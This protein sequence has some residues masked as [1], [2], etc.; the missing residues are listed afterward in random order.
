MSDVVN[1]HGF[2]QAKVC[3]DSPNSAIQVLA[4]HASEAW[5]KN[6]LAALR[7]CFIPAW[8]KKYKKSKGRA[9]EEFDALGLTL[10][11]S[12]GQKHYS[13]WE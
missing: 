13:M 3:S 6:F 4:D 12:R 9:G 8:Q 10:E 11:H 5:E 1:H 7:F 2:L